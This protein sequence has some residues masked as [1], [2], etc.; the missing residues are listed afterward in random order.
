MATV[1]GF[2]VCRGS[3]GFTAG[4]GDDNDQ[5]C[6]VDAASTDDHDGDCVE[7]DGS[8]VCGEHGD[9]DDTDYG[10]GDD[11]YTSGGGEDC[12]YYDSEDEEDFEAQTEE[13]EK[14][15]AADPTREKKQRYI[16]LTED[17]IRARQERDVAMLADVLSIPPGIAFVLLRHFH[18]RAD[19]IQDKWPHPRRRRPPAV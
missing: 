8:D 14:A 11:D 2:D 15:A 12:I 18:W 6:R 7:D 3:G 1:D 19:Q 13:A 4:D 17:D 9:D 5:I 16:V 10:Y